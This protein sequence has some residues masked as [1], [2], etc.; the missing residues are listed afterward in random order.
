MPNL[1]VFTV[2][3]NEYL[4]FSLL[5]VIT[6]SELDLFDDLVFELCETDPLGHLVVWTLLHLGF[7]RTWN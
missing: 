4:A 2:S 1:L 6:T 5:M 3:M 7:C